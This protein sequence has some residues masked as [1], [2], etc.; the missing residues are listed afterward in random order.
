MSK[1]ASGVKSQFCFVNLSKSP[2]LP[3]HGVL[4]KMRGVAAPYKVVLGVEWSGGLTS[5]L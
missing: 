4:S 3:K 1:R 2:D 5:T